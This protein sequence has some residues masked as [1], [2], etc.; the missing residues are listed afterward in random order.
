[1]APHKMPY[2][3]QWPKRVNWKL[4]CIVWKRNCT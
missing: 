2:C 4:N 1:M 3:G